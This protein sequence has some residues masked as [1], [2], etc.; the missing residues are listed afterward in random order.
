MLMR[1][2]AKRQCA[3]MLSLLVVLSREAVGS[4][5]RLEPILG[6]V[7]H[8]KPIDTKAKVAIRSGSSPAS[9][10]QIFMQRG[11]CNGN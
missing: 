6:S 8:C 4:V 11:T 1:R 2:I 10:A 5:P 7:D 9:A 3:P